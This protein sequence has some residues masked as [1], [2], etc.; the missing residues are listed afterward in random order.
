MEG[1]CPAG[2]AGASEY[3]TTIVT[4]KEGTDM[5]RSTQKKV[6]AALAFLMALLMILPMVANLFAIF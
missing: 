1:S 2:C 5:K 6:V 4:K 3:G